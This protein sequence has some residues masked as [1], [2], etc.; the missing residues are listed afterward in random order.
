MMDPWSAALWW[1][2]VVEVVSVAVVGYT[3]WTAREGEDE[4]Q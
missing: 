3:L 2:I 1:V 4:G